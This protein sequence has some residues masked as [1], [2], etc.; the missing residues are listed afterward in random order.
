MSITNQISEP[1]ELSAIAAQLS[2]EVAPQQEPEQAL[3]QVLASKPQ[4]AFSPKV[5]AFA[6]QLSETLRHDPRCRS[7]P[8]LLALGFWLRAGNLERLAQSYQDHTVRLGRGLAFHFAPNNVTTLFAYS[9]LLSLLSGNSNVVRLGQKSTP[10]QHILL[11]IIQELTAQHQECASRI[12]IVRYGHDDVVNRFFC[13]HCAVRIIWGGDSTVEHLRALPMP[14]GSCEL[15]FANKFSWALIDACHYLNHS[16]DEA[17][18][19]ATAQSFIT[20]AFAFG[21]QGCSSP[22][23]ILWHGDP[24]TVTQAQEQFW[25]SVDQALQTRP[26]A[27]SPAQISE[28]FLAASSAIVAPC[29]HGIKPQGKLRASGDGTSYLRLALSSW[30]ELE[31]DAHQ[32]NGLFY[33]LT[34]D[35]LTEVLA[36]CSDHEQTICSLGPT[37]EEWQQAITAT[38]PQGLCRIVA[39]GRA[40]EFNRIWDGYDLIGTMSRALTIAL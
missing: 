26:F 3:A 32:G 10:E 27:L 12:L 37:A 30:D 1:S 24:S 35:S 2:L 28:R 29:Q 20:D 4:A 21:Q 34:V 25:L 13:A 23:L 18:R 17:W 11:N 22:R 16:N 39:L 36:H 14:A 31:R 7:Y 33:E 38:P 6:Q 19:H 9:L 5:M 40:L 15:T 8:D